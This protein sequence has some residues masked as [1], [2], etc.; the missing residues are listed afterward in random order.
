MQVADLGCGA[1]Y[2]A[3]AAAELVGESGRVFAIDVQKDLLE[4]VS[5]MAR[6]KQLLNIDA[7]WGDIE[8]ENG[9]RLRDGS[10]DAV[11]IANTLFQLDD[12][13]GCAR[14]ASRVLAQ[15]GA[16][17]VVEWS[18]SHGG[19]GPQPDHVV[20]KETARELFE[21]AGFEHQRDIDAGE[22]HYGFI[23]RFGAQAS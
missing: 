14:E 8:Q 15:D 13:A 16:L 17:L 2:Y 10:V 1:G 21:L 12:R 20:P 7:V 3:T 9:T 6:E 22:H 19:V 4:S 5:K 11:I 23:M 18:D